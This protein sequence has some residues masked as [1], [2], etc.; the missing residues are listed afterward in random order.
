[1]S[2]VGVH[3][4]PSSAITL[5]QE[6]KRTPEWVWSSASGFGNGLCEPATLVGAVSERRSVARLHRTRRRRRRHVRGRVSRHSCGE[7]R[8]DVRFQVQRGLCLVWARAVS[9]LFLSFATRRAPCSV[10]TRAERGKSK[11]S[12]RSKQF[13]PTFTRH[14]HLASS[15]CVAHVHSLLVRK[16]E[17]A[18]LGCPE[19]LYAFNGRQGQSSDSTNPGWYCQ[20]VQRCSLVQSDRLVC[21]Q[22]WHR[23]DS[24]FAR[25]GAV[26]AAAHVTASEA[27]V[28]FT[29]ALAADPS[30]CKNHR[31][32]IAASLCCN[33]NSPVA[34][35]RG[36]ARGLRRSVLCV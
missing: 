36:L 18:V 34:R 24:T 23:A 2:G 1:V 13:W 22:Q 32:A 17:R 25:T 33:R 31:N 21:Q 10:H 28:A 5:R 35:P 12:R 9:Q 19:H 27:K 8:H 6:R 3:A 11:G 15:I 29:A 26:S 4:G 20:S 16:D 30:S 7:R 14:A